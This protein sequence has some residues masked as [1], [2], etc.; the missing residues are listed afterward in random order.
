MLN[1]KYK[2][3]LILCIEFV[4]YPF[5]WF[6]DR[7][8]RMYCC[9]DKTYKSRGA[10]ENKKVMV[11]VHEWGGYDIMRSKTIKQ[12]VTFNCGLKYQI[13]RFSQNEDVDMVITI[14]QADKH[15]DLDAIRT[16]VSVVEVSNLGMDFSGYAAIYDMIKDEPNRYIIM[17]N[18]S[19]NSVQEVFLEDYIEYMEQNPDVGMLG[20]SYCTKM[21]QTL[22]RDNFTPHLQ[23]FFLLTT[24]DV[25]KQVVALNGGKFPGNGVCHK[26]LLI[27]RGEIRL[28][29]LVQETGYR[30]SVVSPIN[31]VP[32][33]FESYKSWKL[34][35]GDIRQQISTPN[36]I[37]PI[38]K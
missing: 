29:K 25:L 20:I 27:R 24:T 3:Y 13:D 30:L 14:S 19:V 21:I 36:R 8:K 2:F 32:Y 11:V 22:V 4:L 9:R 37:T 15:K 6:G 34:P 26:L 33:K 1:D 35:F 31:G 28:S 38:Q 23:S 17:T 18:S 5:L 16:R 7:F 10:I 12:G